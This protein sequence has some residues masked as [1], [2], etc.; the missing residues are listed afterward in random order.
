[1]LNLL[2]SYSQKVVSVQFRIDLYQDWPLK[3]WE[4]SKPKGVY[5]GLTTVK[6]LLNI[7]KLKTALYSNGSLLMREM[8]QSLKPL[9]AKDV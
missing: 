2:V 9:N 6:T 4:R 7:C 1:M 5:L 3:Y 8:Y